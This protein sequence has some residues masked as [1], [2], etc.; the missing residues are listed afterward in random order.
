[1]CEWCKDDTRDLYCY[2]DAGFEAEICRRCL[3]TY[4]REHYPGGRIQRQL[5]NNYTAEEL[6][7]KE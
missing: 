5:E 6:E 3:Y 2:R 1:M 7:A 4:V